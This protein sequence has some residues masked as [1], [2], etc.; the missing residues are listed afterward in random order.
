MGGGS[1]GEKGEDG[2]R[3]REASYSRIREEG[4]IK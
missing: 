2:A 4:N 1:R 3:G